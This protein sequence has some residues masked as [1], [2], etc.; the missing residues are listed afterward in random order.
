MKDYDQIALFAQK[1]S[2][3]YEDFYSDLEKRSLFEAFFDRYLAP[4]DPSGAME[5][6]EA[7]IALARKDLSE[8]ER[9]IS[10][11]KTKLL[12]AD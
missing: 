12:I 6:Y 7:V 3:A 8:F 1:I 2:N 11:M 4:V 9:M 5:P 10:E